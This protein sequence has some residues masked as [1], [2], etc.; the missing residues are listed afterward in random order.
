[1]GKL[2]KKKE[3]TVKIAIKKST[4]WNKRW[5]HPAA[6]GKP[7]LVI[8]CP[9]SIAVQIVGLEAGDFCD[10]DDEKGN[11][12]DL[13]SYKN[14]GVDPDS[15]TSVLCDI[16]CV[17]NDIA[18]LLISNGFTNI[19]IIVSSEVSEISSVDGISEKLATQ[20]KRDASELNLEL[21]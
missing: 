17:D 3:R 20:I 7:K 12:P 8:D 16:D 4:K 9:Y 11:V 19:D 13:T 21:N 5:I 10:P 14:N 2:D 6:A 1:M 15:M 18:E